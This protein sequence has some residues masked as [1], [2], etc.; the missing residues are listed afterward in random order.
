[1]F[2]P[3]PLVLAVLVGALMGG[4][5]VRAACWC[6]NAFAGQSKDSPAVP[7][8]SLGKAMLVA[9]VCTVVVVAVRVGVVFVGAAGTEF[10]PQSAQTLSYVSL[11]P[12][13]VVMAGML[14]KL[15]PTD[16]GNALGVTFTVFVIGFVL[17]LIPTVVIPALA[18]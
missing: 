2:N 1:M 8:P 18:S 16:F 7:E 12:A 3:L 5:V 6:Y 11:V 15:L 17:S 14:A 13:F 4:I 9:F 10:S